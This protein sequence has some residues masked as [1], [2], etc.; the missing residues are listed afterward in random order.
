VQICNRG[1]AMVDLGVP[2]Y[3]LVE[4]PG[5]ENFLASA[6]PMCAAGEPITRF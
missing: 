5:G 1:G 2:N 3:S 4:Y 6:C